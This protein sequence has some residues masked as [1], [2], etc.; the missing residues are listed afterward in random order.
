MN[1]KFTIMILDFLRIKYNEPTLTGV[2][3]W[4]KVL[5]IVLSLVMLTLSMFPIQKVH[6]QSPLGTILAE[7]TPLADNARALAFDGTHLIATYISGLAVLHFWT[8]PG[9]LAA[10]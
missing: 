9:C 8:V 7:C 6:A 3:R 1:L 10:G 4:R 5:S 2:A